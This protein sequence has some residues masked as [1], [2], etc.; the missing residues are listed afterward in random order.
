M[1]VNYKRTVLK[2]IIYEYVPVPAKHRCEGPKKRENPNEEDAQDSTAVSHRLCSD[3]F[4]YNVV[5]VEG[6]HRHGPD[7]GTTE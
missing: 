2:I 1:N 7:G 6:D 5:A 3:T 4:N